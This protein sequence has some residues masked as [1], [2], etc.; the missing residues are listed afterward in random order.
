[1]ISIAGLSDVKT[2]VL[3]EDT[4]GFYTG[5]IVNVDD[6]HA[7][8][9]LDQVSAINY[10]DKIKAPILL[11]HGSKDTRVDSD[12][13]EDFY[14]SAK[15]KIDVKYVEINNGTHFFDDNQSQQ[16]LYSEITAFL[17]TNLKP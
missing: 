5:N 10:I 13:S 8:E 2:M 11:I 3:D 17:D 1:V 7:V 9:Q 6:E 15:R 16:I 12:Q 4:F 14:D